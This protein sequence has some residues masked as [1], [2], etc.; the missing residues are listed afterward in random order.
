MPRRLAQV[1]HSANGRVGVEFSFE[2]QPSL[3]AIYV[4]AIG[5]PLG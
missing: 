4:N 2:E 5:A 1:P 3:Y